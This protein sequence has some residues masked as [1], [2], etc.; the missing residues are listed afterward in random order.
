MRWR[1]A[2][3]VNDRQHTGMILREER[4]ENSRLAQDISTIMS[5]R[6]N[7]RCHRNP[8]LFH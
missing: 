8:S 6:E 3:I 7:A 5:V 1:R 4:V 2:S